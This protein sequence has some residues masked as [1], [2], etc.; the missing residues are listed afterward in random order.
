MNEDDA[1][2]VSDILRKYGVSGSSSSDA[3]K[4]AAAP[5]KTLARQARPA[6]GGGMGNGLFVILILNFG[7]FAA[8]N[9]LHLPAVA[10]LAL[11]HWRPQWWQVGLA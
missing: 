1:N 7:L 5:P 9:L 6:A 8:S 4:P 10:D 2:D 11:N 3:P